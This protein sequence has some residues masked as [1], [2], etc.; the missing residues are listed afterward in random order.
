M[1]PA[2]PLR[3]LSLR[4]IRREIVARRRW[5]LFPLWVLLAL[6]GVLVMLIGSSHLRSGVYTS[7]W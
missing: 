5:L 7:F 4:L 1:K 3:T 6:I 2:Q